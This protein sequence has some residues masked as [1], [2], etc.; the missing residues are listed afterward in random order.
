RQLSAAYADQAQSLIASHRPHVLHVLQ[1]R[2]LQ[3]YSSSQGAQFTGYLRDY[4]ARE[5]S[6]R[7]TDNDAT[8]EKLLQEVGKY[9]EAIE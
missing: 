5:L 3:G 7:S 1:S 2:V 4:I 8:G 6:A 9:Y